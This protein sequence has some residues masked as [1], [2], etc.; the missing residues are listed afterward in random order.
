MNAT[1][2]VLEIHRLSARYGKVPALLPTSLSVQPGSIVTVIGANGA[3]KST[4]LNAVMGALPQGGQA[5][6]D[7]VFAGQSIA[8]WQVE[9]R[10]ALGMS[11]VPEK[12]ELFAT[13]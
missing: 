9:R 4:L 10:V 11:L 12:R 1:V 13:M 2:P 3:G 7:V 8:D 5:S 6:G